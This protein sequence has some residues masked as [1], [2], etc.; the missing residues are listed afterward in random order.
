MTFEQCL[1][2]AVEAATS[3]SE[4]LMSLLGKVDPREKSPRD[5]VSEADLASQELIYEHLNDQFPE[6]G[7]LGEESTTS[8][9]TQ[10]W[11]LLDSERPTWV[12]DPLDGTMNYLYQ[13]PGFAVSIG[14][15]CQG[16]TEVAVIY[17]PWLKE[18]YTAVRG[19]AALRNGEP[20]R[21]TACDTLDNALLAASLPPRVT[22]NSVEMQRFVDISEHCRALRR[23]GSAALNLA[24][25]AC[26]R[27]DGYWATTVNAWDIAA[28]VLIAEQAGAA[29]NGVA[30]QAFS[31]RS[32]DFCVTATPA[33]QSQLLQRIRAF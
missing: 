6:F 10:Q 24:Y 20:I 13:L 22:A 1:S 2:P 9:P 21:T 4:K 15:V 29:L 23:M 27:L 11:E 25:V 7:F 17:D 26:G 28:G 19:A 3:A 18:L 30:E 14:L 8:S 16:R 31:L 32:A 5:L 33:L 12:V